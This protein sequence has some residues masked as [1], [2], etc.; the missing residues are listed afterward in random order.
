MGQR[1]K[2]NSNTELGQ[3]QFL[4][5]TIKHLLSTGLQ[6]SVFTETLFKLL[7]VTDS[8][9]TIC[10]SNFLLHKFKTSLSND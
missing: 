3:I 9:R 2:M 6:I 7:I 10:N 5:E 1:D 4:M 8:L